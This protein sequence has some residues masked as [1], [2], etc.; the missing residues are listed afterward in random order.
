MYVDHARLLL[1]LSTCLAEH[2]QLHIVPIRS[3]DCDVLPVDPGSSRITR[4]HRKASVVL[5]CSVYENSELGPQY[6]LC[7]VSGNGRHMSQRIGAT[8][9]D[10]FE[11]TYT[12]KYQ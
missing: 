11:L 1:R 4:L 5:L 10:N 8:L 7:S 9:P 6:V 12:A 2:V 3:F